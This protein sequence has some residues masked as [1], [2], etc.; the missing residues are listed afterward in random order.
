M[1]E[2]FTINSLILSRGTIMILHETSVK[3]NRNVTSRNILCSLLFFLN[4]HIKKLNRKGV[5][6]SCALP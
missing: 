3:K 5:F 6:L 1:K 2:F 4:I